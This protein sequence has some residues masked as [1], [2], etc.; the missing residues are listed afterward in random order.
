MASSKLRYVAYIRKSEER[1]ERQELSHDAQ[2][3]KVKEQFPGLNIVRWMK[4]SKSA[5]KPGRPLFNEMLEMI[6]QGKADGIIAWHPNRCSRNEIDSARITYALRGPLKD[7]KFCSYTFENSAEGIMMLQM[8]MNQSQYESSKQGRDVKRGMEQKAVGGER[9]GVVPQGYMKVPKRDDTGNYIKR[10]D[11]Y[12]TVTAIDSERYDLVKK[13]WHLLIYESK[14]P[15]QIR[16]IATEEWGYTVR[17][18]A[19]T[20]GGPLGLSG[21]YRIFNNRFY[22][23]YIPHNGKWYPGTHQAMITLDEFDYAQKLLGSHAKRRQGLNEYAFSGM[24]ICGECG[25]Q[26][27]AKTNAKLIKS[28]GEIKKYVHY[29]CTRKS[30]KRPCSQ[31]VYTSVESLEA[32]IDAELAK[33]TI[34]PE[35]RDM[36]LE[37]I[38]RN[39]KQQAKLHNSVHNSQEKARGQIK[40]Q[41]DKLLDLRTR[42]LLDD[43]EYLEKKNSL[44]FELDAIDERL[45]GVEQSSESLIQ[46]TERAFD[47]ATYARAHFQSTKDLAIKREIARTLGENFVLKDNKLSFTPSEWLEPIAKDYPTLEKAYLKVRTN[48]K[49]SAKEK[50]EAL[51][52]IFESWRA[53]VHAISTAISSTSPLGSYLLSGNLGL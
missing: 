19:K 40:Q 29:Y 39:Y 9:P 17:K 13:M 27:V 1:Q 37:I 12:I 5:F 51:L 44:K 7:L 26:I 6:E 28:T 31:N 42:D 22:A 46:L 24:I 34:I 25:C 52:Q 33:H 21:I 47:F 41:L 32:Q 8:V 14:M 50:Q 20:G 23:G 4:E 2:E 48:K 35:F 43:A 38:N 16:K 18:T 10:K 15:Y 3:R 49:A 30:I 36:A 11:K 45:R 53:I